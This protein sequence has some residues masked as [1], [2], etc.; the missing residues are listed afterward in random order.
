MSS[1]SIIER[2]REACDQWD[3]SKINSNDLANQI[4]ALASAIENVGTAIEHEAEDWQRQLWIAAEVDDE[5]GTAQGETVVRIRNWISG[6]MTRF[7]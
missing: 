3:A 4:I 5:L 7:S 2:M 1:A 6:L